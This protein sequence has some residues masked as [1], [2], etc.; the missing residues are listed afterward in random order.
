MNDQHSALFQIHSR[1]VHKRLF[2]ITVLS[3]VILF[4][5][6]GIALLLQL[7][8][9]HFSV[10]HAGA[11]LLVSN[12]QD[13]DLSVVGQ[14]SLHAETVDAI[15][16][17]MGSPMVGTGKV[18]EQVA[19]QV[20]IDD[21]FALAVWWTETN[22]GASGVGLAYHNPGG[23]RG[24]IGYPS[25]SG[26]YTIYP[27]YAA[28]ATNWFHLLRNNYVDRGLSTVYA[29]SHP[30]VG[31]SSS[32]LWAGKVVALMQRYHAEAPP[33]SP[34]PT[35][36][37][38]PTVSTYTFH[39]YK[40]V[41]ASDADYLI[42]QREAQEPLKQATAATL[43]S[44]SA[45]GLPAGIVYIIAIFALFL[46]L[47]IAAW[48]L[49]IGQDTRVLTRTSS[50]S[51]TQLA[52]RS[53]GAPVVATSGVYGAG[54]NSLAPPTWGLTTQTPK[55]TYTPHPLNTTNPAPAPFY[56]ATLSPAR[57]TTPPFRRTILLPSLPD[58]G[59]LEHEP[60]LTAIG[61]DPHPAGLLTRYGK[62][63]QG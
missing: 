7:S 1:P 45:S 61:V 10:Q 53:N 55:N 63:Q 58:T 37:P 12:R 18:I 59:A 33:P 62:T 17:R 4:I 49:K 3:L 6:G 32:Y 29:I 47:L 28:A 24:S 16:S 44:P 13:G 26:G 31:T 27:S 60:A 36:T 25:G 46:S 19:S 38:N 39:H 48:G 11:T 5:G 57:K 15:F 8:T 56:P 20:H 21:A 14:P 41:A 30:Y 34:T 40:M 2:Q 51:T 50:L 35:V 42:L 23:V 52:G 22:D 43:Q 54:F 9:A